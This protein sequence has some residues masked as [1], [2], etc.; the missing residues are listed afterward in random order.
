MQDGLFQL[1]DKPCVKTDGSGTLG[2]AEKFLVHFRRYLE[3][4]APGKRFFRV[5]FGFQ[6]KIN[7]L[8]KAFKRGFV[9]LAFKGF[10][11]LNTGKSYRSSPC[12]PGPSEGYTPYR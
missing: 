5:R 8:L 10:N 1:F 9:C 3:S 4:N 2:L 6:V 7:R 11:G 12:F